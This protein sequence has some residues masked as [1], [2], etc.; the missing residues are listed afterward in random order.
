M[1][2]TLFERLRSGVSVENSRVDFEC[3]LVYHANMKAELIR[4]N[5]ITDDL[6]N[7]I[8]IKL[9]RVPP[10]LEKPHG[11][12]YSLVYIVAGHRA[13]GYDNAEGKGDHRHYGEMEGPYKY[14]SLRK[15]AE[16]FLAD[17]EAY[18]RGHQ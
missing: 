4:H 18:K 5:K 15:L 10:T 9:W 3:L 6:G 11:F 12:K 2:P 14:I 13:I 16:D 7:T 1:S 8:E 17:M